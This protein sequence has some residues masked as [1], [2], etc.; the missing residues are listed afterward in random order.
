M[1]VRAP[2]QA[3]SSDQA[4]NRRVSPIGVPESSAI[5]A[6]CDCS[7]RTETYVCVVARHDQVSARMAR[8]QLRLRLQRAGAL[9][10]TRSVLSEMHPE[11]PAQ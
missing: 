2:M 5:N 8:A 9:V 7:H 11:P 4:A 6:E 10:A 3:T 1:C